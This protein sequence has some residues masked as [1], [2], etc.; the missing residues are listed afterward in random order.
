V[1][2]RPSQPITSSATTCSAPA[3]LDTDDPPL[4]LCQRGHLCLHD[5]C[6]RRE[7][8]AFLGE[9]IEKIPLRH[10]GD[11]PARGRNV[12]EVCDPVAALADR[13]GDIANFRVRQLQEF[14][15][16]PELVHDLQGRWVHGIAAEIAQE[17]RVLFQN[18]GVDS[19]SAQQ[20]AEHHASRSAADDAHLRLHVPIRTAAVAWI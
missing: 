4:R 6:Q 10:D 2:E 19:G 16:Q 7:L 5:H 14:F 20:V 17:I 1:E 3:G 11:I 15:Q 9:E 8:S 12:P 13:G 18:A